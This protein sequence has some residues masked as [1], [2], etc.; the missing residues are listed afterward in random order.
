VSVA[1]LVYAT[2]A[3]RQHAP[4][5]ARCGGACAEHVWRL[6]TEHAVVYNALLSE[7]D[8]MNPAG[9]LIGSVLSFPCMP[10]EPGQGVTLYCLHKVMVDSAYRGHGIGAALMEACLHETDRLGA[11]S[12][13]TVN[14]TNQAAINLYISW[15]FEVTEQSL[16]RGYYEDAE[17]G[18]RLVI[19]RPRGAKR[20][21]A[22]RL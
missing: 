16:V 8:A 14:P 15:G 9:T 12:F 17:S 20:T 3:A 7:G 1:L 10:S 21:T 6:W 22:P 19:V 2:K 13:L 18:N 11:D 4:P 5:D